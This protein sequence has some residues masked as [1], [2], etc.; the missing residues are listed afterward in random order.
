ML[1]HLSGPP[2]QIADATVNKKNNT[3]TINGSCFIPLINFVLLT[4]KRESN[5]QTTIRYDKAYP[6]N[7]RQ[8]A[9][10]TGKK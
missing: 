4:E 6:P 10:S 8:N 5:N 9:K 1:L 7:G 2:F 3:L